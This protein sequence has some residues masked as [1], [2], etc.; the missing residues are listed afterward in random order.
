MCSST[1]TATY[2]LLVSIQTSL[3]SPNT[4]HTFFQDPMQV[5]DAFGR[6]FPVP[7]EYNW[8]V[9]A[10]AEGNLIKWH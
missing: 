4:R 6:L 5:E 2:N 9:S 1:N 3:P 7:V 8:E 10:D